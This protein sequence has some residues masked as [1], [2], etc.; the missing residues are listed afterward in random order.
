MTYPDIL[1]RL[2]EHFNAGRHD[3]A[4][5]FLEE[6]KTASPELNKEGF[7]DY[8]LGRI[9]YFQQV[10]DRARAH[11]LRALTVNPRH[12][13]AK[14]FLARSM[15]ALGERE[16][17]IRLY[18]D[19]V[20]D[21]PS[22]VQIND[23]TNDAV[24]SSPFAGPDLGFLN[25]PRPPRDKGPL[26]LISVVILCYNK[27]EFTEQCLDALYKNTEYPNY[28][29]IVVDNASVDDTPFLIETFA[30]RLTFI[31]SDRNLGFVGGNNKAAGR[32]RG[33]Y[34]AFLNNDTVV[35]PDWL[36]ELQ[37]TFRLHPDTGAAGSMLVYPDGRL[38]E[39]GGIIFRDGTGW[40]YGRNADPNA[41]PYQ[42]A[43]EVDYCSGAALM[44]RTDLFL[45]LGKFDERFAPAYYEDTDLCF[46]VRRLGYAVRYCPHSVVVHHEGATAGTDLNAGFKKY[47]T[48]NAPKFREKWAKELSLQHPLDESLRY[49]F[50]NRGKG[51]RILIIDDLP[52]LPDRAAGSL[53]LYH[54]V[55]QMLNLG[56][57]ITYVHLMGMNLD[58]AARKHMKALQARGVEFIWFSYET[59]WAIRDRAEVRP[60]LQR[61]IAGL[62]LPLRKFDLAYICFWHIGR[63]FIDL[64]RQQDPDLPIVVDSMDLHYL[65]EMR[66]A[67]IRKDAA[68]KKAALETKR[69][70]LE[71]YAKAD[72]ATTVTL[73]DRETLRKDLRGTPVFIMT[74]VHDPVE[75][76]PGFDQRADLA[77]VGNFNHTPNEDAAVYFVRDVFPLI[78][79]ELPGV[80]LFIV[81][82]KPTPAVTALASEAVIVTGWVPDVKPYLERCRIEVVPLRYGAGNKGKVGEAFACGIPMVMTAIGA[83]GMKVRDGE[84]AFIADARE[85]FAERTVRLYRD[86]AVWEKFAALGKLHVA[87]MYSSEL[88]RRRLEYL[89]SFTSR[90][91]FRTYRALACPLP[92]EVSVILP[93]PENR[94][95]AEQVLTA[96]QNTVA[97]SHELLAVSP[98]L[99]DQERER[100]AAAMPEFRMPGRCHGTLLE[101]YNDA[102]AHA[103]GDT[104]ILLGR[105]NGREPEAP[106]A[107][108]AQTDFKAPDGAAEAE[109]SAGRL[110][111]PRTVL[112]A[113]GGLDER[114]RSWQTAAAD[115]LLRA[116]LGGISFRGDHPATAAALALAY[117]AESESVLLREKWG[118]T[119]F[120]GAEDTGPHSDRE[121]HYPV[122]R[123][124]FVA[125]WRQA[126]YFAKEAKPRHALAKLC[127][128]LAE[129]HAAPR[130]GCTVEFPDVLGKIDALLSAAAPGT[131]LFDRLGDALGLYPEA[132]PPALGAVE[133]LIERGRTEEAGR[134]MNA[135]FPDGVRQGMR[136]AV[137]EEKLKALAAAL[138]AGPGVADLVSIVILTFNQLAY[139]KECVAS[140]RKHTPEPHEIIFVDNGSTDGTVKWLRTLAREH[141]RCRLIENKKNQGFAK[142]CNQGIEA[143][144]GEYVLLLNN[145]VVVTPEW[146]AGLLECLK[147]AP[148]AGIVGPMTNTISGPQKTG[149]ASCESASGLDEY[150]RAFRERNRHRRVPLRRIVGFCMLFRRSLAAEIG[151]LDETFGTGNFEDDDY[152]LRAALSGRENRI[153]GDVFIH[154]YGSRSFIGNRIN[155][156]STLTGNR[157]RFLE[158]WG[159]LDA[160]SGPGARLAVVNAVEGA[161]EYFEQGEHENAAR[162]LLEGM[163]MAPGSRELHHALARVMIDA[164][165]YEGALDALR[166]VPA[167]GR[168]AETALLCGYAE[169]GLGLRGDAGASADRALEQDPSSAAALTFKGLL[170]EKAGDR[171]AAREWYR[172]ACEADPGHGEAFTRRGALLREEGNQE[173]ARDLIEHGF[174]LNPTALDG[175]TA[176]YAVIEA[177]G[178]YE[179]AEAILR[180]AKAL[181]PLHRR[182]A[183]LLIDALLKQ[184]KHAAAMQEIEQAMLRYGID[185][186]ILAAAL[187]VRTAAGPHAGTGE[188]R[189][190]LCMIVKNEE[191]RLPKC[192]MSVK[193]LVQEIIVVDTGSA[194]R[195]KSIARAFGAKVFDFPWTGDFS[196]ARNFSL[197]QAGGD[198][199]LALDADETLAPQDHARLSALL[200]KRPSK[201]AAYAMTTR[202]YI[203]P[204]QTTGWTAN[205]G[206]YAQE[207][208][209]TGWFP[210]VKVRLFTRDKRIRFSNPVH[211]LVEPSL[212]ACGV[213]ARDIDVPVH[214]YGKLDAEK[215]K[216]KGEEYYLLGRKKLEESGEN[217]AALRELAIQAGGLKK[218]EE[219]LDLWQRAVPLIPDKELAWL[220]MASLYLQMDRFGEA[221]AVSRKAVERAADLKEAVSNNALCELYAGDVDRAIRGLEKLLAAEPE[222]PA[223]RIMLGVAY[224]FKGNREKGTAEFLRLRLQGAA[225]A[226]AILPFARKM[227]V[228][229][230][231]EYALALVGTAAG[232][233]AVNEELTALQDECAARTGAAISPAV[234]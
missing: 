230:R 163:R 221:L 32:V 80:K 57:R 104:I 202:N 181:H 149:G 56:C 213:A 19:C 47:Q 110:V 159:N 227:A 120:A 150:A 192:L 89:M 146:L 107:G 171:A 91:A 137:F 60:Y 127:A 1:A 58:A 30:R 114:F 99:S 165:Q 160:R 206:V 76:T 41:P 59:W 231:P 17:V 189:V 176:Y 177:D 6:Q 12:F 147:S 174:I 167:G 100:F 161:H 140:I 216:I 116:G 175:I 70:E 123:D 64:I 73:Q 118:A 87:S 129:F 26:P 145:D 23:Y 183:F 219:A 211:E 186:G 31:R 115:L 122:D 96:I 228:A 8:Q 135:W 21:K 66:Q 187:E 224:L 117:S 95:Q 170:A 212:K 234:P 204:I 207:E 130:R 182:I 126:G 229:G 148:D 90:A 75:N 178:A 13:Q 128:A 201:P 218:F 214:H 108:L 3:Q 88:K 188:P 97:R 39:A 141:G 37:R 16:D 172:R 133:Y 36:T 49:R 155:Y 71:T 28:E 42:F 15:E 11:F 151:L 113:T 67:E 83:E 210:S 142:G 200:A 102:L 82:N 55:V 217:A 138:A 81:G 164:G 168:D 143:S 86:R 93:L 72:A 29:V 111:I 9:L 195:T 179:R 153:A 226:E 101:S 53:R 158:K 125:A 77:F 61:L 184:G 44:V 185:D 51:R 197:D 136:S 144:R 45:K 46:G 198:W 50:S 121:L 109:L 10:F 225:L 199:I 132:L 65:R 162:R 223:A 69:A 38:Q 154:H 68:L 22:L 119:L 79:R 54:T 84:H 92:P 27:M 14:F 24:M 208:A 232:L 20:A 106:A 205:D 191:A 25:M 4:L 180:E 131:A 152:C 166:A 48:L 2:Q 62:D 103:L 105:G 52:P 193:P 33:E 134:A 94:A 74:D 222:Y 156:G 98:G 196:A 139:T 203:V 5:R 40:N 157:K 190:S 194:D 78:R 18:A 233:G 220:N 63:Y 112:D 124:P 43:R 173:E 35:T 34:I 7:L 215:E 169:E 209:G 85:E